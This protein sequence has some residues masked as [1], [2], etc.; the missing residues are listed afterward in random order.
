MKPELVDAIAASLACV[1]GVY[2]YVAAVFK[3]QNS[4]TLT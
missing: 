2:V 4:G 3:H 1:G